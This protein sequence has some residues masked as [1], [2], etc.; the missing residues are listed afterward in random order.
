MRWAE[1]E[2]WMENA[3]HFI[4]GLPRSGSTLLS[5]ILCQNPAFQAAMTSPVGTLYMALE[6]AMSRSNETSVFL[7]RHQRR[8]LLRGVFAGYYHAAGP[9]TLIFDT[10]RLWC[11]RVAALTEL[12]PAAKI[13]CCVRPVPWIIDSI[14]RQ[15][16]RNPFEL[17]GLFG[18]EP[19][20][21]VYSRANRVASSDGMVGY[22]LDALREACFGTHS[23]RIILMDYETLSREPAGAIA[24]LYQLLGLPWFVHDFT[25]VSYAAEAFDAALGTPGL[26]TVRA[27][28]EWRPRETVLP[29]DLFRRFARD[30]FWLRPEPRLDHIPKI[31]K[32]DW[33]NPPSSA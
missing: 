14:E 6:R 3:I 10:N 21:T 17:S 27:P 32:L 12:F 11:A 2:A 25:N 19:G 30:S 22:A 1:I 16:Q 33:D 28:V 8:A 31:L 23:D 18:Y 15:A 29:P 20:A 24:T 13:I 4:S 26:H 9:T 5:A 7:D